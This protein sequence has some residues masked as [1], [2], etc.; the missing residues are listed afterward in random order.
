[1]RGYGFGDAKQV[2]QAVETVLN[3]DT[4]SPTEDADRIK[5]EAAEKEAQ[6]QAEIQRQ[7]AEQKAAE[8]R[9]NAIQKIKTAKIDG[10]SF[11][12]TALSQSQKSE[13]DVIADI[14]KQ[15][16][17]IKVFIVGHTCN[18]GYKNINLKKGLKRAK[19]G[20]EYLNEK[21]I[22]QERISVDTKGETQPFVQNIS[23]ENRKQNRR[24]EF[25]IE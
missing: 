20:K 16:S 6:R 14:L 13:L 11:D 3:N 7:Q 18:I 10:Y 17:D 8:E 4:W 21:G 24:I 22:S 12:E 1:L 5:A 19:A 2:A 9:K 15:Y 23:D 25:I